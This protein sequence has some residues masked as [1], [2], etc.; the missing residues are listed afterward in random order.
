M[1]KSMIS[2][3]IDIIIQ[4]LLSVLY[5]I[6]AEELKLL[7]RRHP[8]AFTEDEIVEIGELFYAGKSGGSVSFE[9]FIEAIDKVVDLET[10]DG[11]KVD[12]HGNPLELGTCGNEF[13]F[14]KHHSNYTPEELDVKLTHTEPQGLRD[15]F[16]LNCVKAVRWC[17]DTATGWNYKSITPDMIL[18]RTIYLETIAAVPGMVAAIVRIHVIYLVFE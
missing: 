15:R 5:R 8:T 4:S 13:L 1:V 7:L 9:R 2:F 14:F 3:F 10:E 16:A 11:K 6:E 17:F 18:Q 12:T